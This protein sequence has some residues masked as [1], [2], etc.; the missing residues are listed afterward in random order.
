MQIDAI[1]KNIE[2]LLEGAANNT[3]D[4]TFVDESS[5]TEHNASINY[6]DEMTI[7]STQVVVNEYDVLSEALSQELIPLTQGTEKDLVDV[8]NDNVGEFA[9]AAH[10]HQEIIDLPQTLPLEQDVV[11]R[12][13]SLTNQAMVTAGI[14]PTDAYYVTA[15]CSNEEQVEMIETALPK[16]SSLRNTVDDFLQM[17]LIIFYCLF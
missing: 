12:A 4:V 10:A 15:I 6:I 5:I 8:K 1:K 9:E 3:T 13:S 14:L 11:S 7:A 2:N 16:G 17:H